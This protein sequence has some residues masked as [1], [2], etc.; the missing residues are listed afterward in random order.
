MDSG[1][2]TDGGDLGLRWSGPGGHAHDSGVAVLVS[3]NRYRLGRAV[4]SGTR[5]R[6]DDRLLGDDRRRGTL[7]PT[8]SPAG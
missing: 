3:N 4:G 1:E 8:V 7:A 6:I 2:R 5:P